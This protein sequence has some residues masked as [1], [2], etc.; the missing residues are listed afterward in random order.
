MASLAGSVLKSIGLEGELL[1]NQLLAESL[2]TRLFPDCVLIPLTLT[3]AQD[4]DAPAVW[5]RLLKIRESMTPSWTLTAVS[6]L[7]LESKKMLL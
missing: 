3:T 6:L 1:S 2:A 5:I 4:D 7:R